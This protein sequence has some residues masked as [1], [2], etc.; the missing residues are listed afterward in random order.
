M[1]VG[2]KRISLL[3]LLVAFSSVRLQAQFDFNT[4]NGSLVITHY[5]GPG[6]AVDIPIA[7]RH[8]STWDSRNFAPVQKESLRMNE[9]GV[10]C[11]SIEKEPRRRRPQVVQ[12]AAARARRAPIADGLL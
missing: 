2:P 8:D 5:S 11:P 6:G 3:L 1:R 9:R 4:N 10:T 12:G 7:L